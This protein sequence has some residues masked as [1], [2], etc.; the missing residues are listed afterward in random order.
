MSSRFLA[1][2]SLLN[3]DDSDDG[4]S[5]GN[6]A[7][8]DRG[9]STSS[10]TTTV[11]TLYKQPTTFVFSKPSDYM[12]PWDE[13]M[14]PG[15]AMRRFYSEQFPSE[16]RQVVMFYFEYFYGICPI[17]HP[18]TFLCRLVCGS[19]DALLIDVMRAK[20]ARLI[21]KHTGRHVDLDAI[22][23]NIN[24]RLLLDLEQPSFD[25]IRA[26]VLMTTLSGGECKFMSYNSLVCLACSMVLRLGWN[27]LDLSEKDAKNIPWLEWAE[28]E[29]QR[30][31]FW[32]VYQLDAYQALLADRQVSISDAR[33]HTGTPGS[34]CTWDD[35]SIAQILHWPTRHLQSI[36]KPTI[37]NT[38]ALSYTFIDVCDL[39]VLLSHINQFLWSIRQMPSRARLFSGMLLGP[40][41]GFEKPDKRCKVERSL[42][43]L[44]RFR[45]LHGALQAWRD[46]LVPADDLKGIGQGLGHFSQFGSLRHRQHL[47]RVR[48]FCLQCY[49]VPFLHLLHLSNRPSLFHSSAS[50][51]TNSAFASTEEY[52]VLREML[53]SSFSSTTNDSLLAYDVVEESWQ[54]CLDSIFELSEFLD[55]NRDI[56]LDRSDQITIF[57][58]FTSI[59]VLIRHIRKCRNTAEGVGG[60]YGADVMA[61]SLRVVRQLWVMLKDLGFL[62]GVRGMERLLRQMQV[63]EVINA[64]DLFSGLK[65]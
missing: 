57:C 63:E 26:V 35:I 32:I 62:W 2:G 61:K 38:G 50:K 11:P 8:T 48:Y 59:T 3:S 6:T 55:R 39:T 52:R 18:A 21:G 19:V 36:D 47:M 42:F 51:P 31:T 53:S 4:T 10:D 22:T 43:E 9:Q 41:L 58:L 56:S 20:T 28:L 12:R 15:E 7:A 30:R 54:I 16:T 34:D 37:I 1:I 40:N 13:S 25:Y 29:T 44:P 49:Y 17:F 65:L 45:E 33:I 46:R 27:S 64:A 24:K 5:G 23:E 60:C 14:S